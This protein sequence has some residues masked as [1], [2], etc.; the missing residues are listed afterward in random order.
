MLHMDGP[1]IQDDLRKENIKKFRDSEIT[2]GIF[3]S[4]PQHTNVNYAWGW[5]GALKIKRESLVT[6]FRVL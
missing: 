3:Y 2:F 5:G 4:F 1:V 6:A